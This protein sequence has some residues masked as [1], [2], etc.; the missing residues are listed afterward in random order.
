VRL[1]LLWRE[2]VVGDVFD[3]D[4]L[5]LMIVLSAMPGRATHLQYARLMMPSQGVIR[6]DRMPPR[7]L[8]F[9]ATPRCAVQTPC[10]VHCHVIMRSNATVANGLPRP[11]RY[12]QSARD[13]RRTTVTE[14]KHGSRGQHCWT[15]LFAL[16]L[17]AVQDRLVGRCTEAGLRPGLLVLLEPRAHPLRSIVEGITQWFVDTLKRITLSHEHLNTRQWLVL[18]ISSTPLTMQ[19]WRRNLPARMLSSMLSGEWHRKL[20]SSTSCRL[21]DAR[22]YCISRFAC[23][24]CL[25]CCRM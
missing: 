9:D 16:A 17:N 10:V 5:A 1:L 13:R 14:Q 3:E 21:C 25:D 20:A 11:G 24:E 8:D 6:F 22:L 7:Q 23:R 4:T 18:Q 15:Y 2:E 19:F 12:M